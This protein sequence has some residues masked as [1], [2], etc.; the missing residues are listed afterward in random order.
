MWRRADGTSQRQLHAYREECMSPRESD[1]QD[2]KRLLRLLKG[3]PRV[4][5]KFG[6]QKFA[7]T[8]HMYV[9]SDF[10]GCLLTRC[11][12]SGLV[13]TFGR[14]TVKASSTPKYDQFELRRSRILL[15]CSRSF[16]WNVVTGDL[17]RMGPTAKTSSAHGFSRCVGNM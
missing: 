15:D 8:I 11:S 7:D 12:T 16:Y 2:L 3:K 5:L 4:L 1:F 14:H 10:A 9:D 6:R 13:A 17:A